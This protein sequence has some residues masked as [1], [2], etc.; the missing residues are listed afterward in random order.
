MSENWQQCEIC[1]VV[2]DK[3]PGSI[4]KHLSCDGL[5]HYKFIIQFTSDRIFKTGKHLAKLQATWLIVSFTL[6]FCSQ[7]RTTNQLT[8]I[9]CVL[10]TETVTNC[11]YVNRQINEC[12]LSTN[13][14]LL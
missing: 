5:V 2:N 9:T 7:K 3:S 12:L 10:R 4:A 11:C 8:K 13:I 1:I 6:H 14:K